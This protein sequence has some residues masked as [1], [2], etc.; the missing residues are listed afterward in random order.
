MKLFLLIIIIIGIFNALSA[1]NFGVGTNTPAEKL[2]VNGNTR[3][4][5]L[6]LTNGGAV[7]DN[8]T[9][10]NVTGEV[11]YK[12]GHR[13]A[14]LRYIIATSGVFPSSGRTTQEN[15]ILGEIAFIGQLKILAGEVVPKGWALCNGQT[16]PLNQNMALFNLLGY[17]YGG[18][19][20]SFNLPNL[21]GAAPV[22]QG[23]NA[24]GYTWGRAQK[25]D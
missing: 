7:Q 20:F 11:G 21:Q 2:D 15:A 3:L 10:S 12:K 5:R 1:Q 13:G 6:I 14:G 24:A 9:K 23:T 19:G 4:E 22:G 8:L 18:S 16:L 25:S 17:T